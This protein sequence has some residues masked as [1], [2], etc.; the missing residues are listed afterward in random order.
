M[1]RR[2]LPALALGALAV[3]CAIGSFD[4]STQSPATVSTRDLPEGS[5][6]STLRGVIVDKQSRDLIAGAYI[7]LQCSC[8]QAQREV[9]TNAEGLYGFNKLPAG[10]YTIQV[11]YGRADHSKVLQVKSSQKIRVD[12]TIDPSDDY[13]RT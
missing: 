12:F 4:K 1:D 2:T 11:L 9:Q 13:V 7:I 5:Q 10:E 3:A 6:Y 8:L